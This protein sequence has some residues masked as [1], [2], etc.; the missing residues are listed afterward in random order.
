MTIYVVLKSKFYSSLLKNTSLGRGVE[1]GDAIITK[2]VEYVKF[3]PIYGL[4]FV[5]G[6]AVG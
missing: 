1:K 6:G 5:S 4:L 2:I 3:I